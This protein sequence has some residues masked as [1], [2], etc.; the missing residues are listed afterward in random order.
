MFVLESYNIYSLIG[1]GGIYGNCNPHL[2]YSQRMGMQVVEGCYPWVLS[3]NCKRETVLNNSLSSLERFLFP[4]LN[5]VQI[6]FSYAYGFVITIL[7][8][9]IS[10]LLILNQR[11]RTSR[12]RVRPDKARACCS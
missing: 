11:C 9:Y 6:H 10:I 5:L 4:N 7:L 3:L 8:D 1:G 12:L 2:S